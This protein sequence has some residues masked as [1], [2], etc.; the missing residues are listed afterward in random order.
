[1]WNAAA[2]EVISLAPLLRGEGGGEGLLQ[3][4]LKKKCA[5]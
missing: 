1:M 4:I 2:P 3:Q 5:R